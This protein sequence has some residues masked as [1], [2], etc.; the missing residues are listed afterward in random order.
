[1]RKLKFVIPGM[2]A[3][4][5]A[6]SGGANLIAGPDLFTYSATT[7][8]TSNNPMTFS[9]TVVVLNTTTDP[10]SFVPKCPNPRT[11]IYANAAHT[12]TPIWDSN[13]RVPLILCAAPL[14]VTLDANKSVSYTLT[15]TGSEVLGASGTPGTY[16]VVDEV[17]LDGI[18]YGLSGGQVTLAR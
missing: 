15:A 6:C 9:T 8:V 5:A 17:T 2:I 7:Q 14:T 1:M 10:I 12:G 11:L 13:V 3:V 4:S 16:Y 18:V